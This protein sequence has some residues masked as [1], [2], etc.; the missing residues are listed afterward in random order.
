MSAAELAITSAFQPAGEKAEENGIHK[1]PFKNG[2]GTPPAA[3]SIPL[4]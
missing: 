3:T 2:S 1:L 4:A